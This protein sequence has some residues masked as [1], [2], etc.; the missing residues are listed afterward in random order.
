[1]SKFTTR[2]ILL[3]CHA[4]IHRAYHA[5]PDFSTRDGVPTGGLY[6]VCTMLIKAISD[7]RPDH[8]IA[9]YDLPKP[10]FRHIAYDDYKGGRAKTDEDLK[11][12]LQSSKEI[13]EA[14]GIPIYEQEGFE[15]DDLLGTIAEILKKDPSHEVI[16][17]SGDM[18][19]L[20]LV[21][22]DQ[23]KVFTLK[24]SINDTVLYNEDAVLERYGFGSDLI[25]DYK[26]L[27]GDPSDNIIGIKGIGAKTA[28]TLLTNFGTIEDIYTALEDTPERFSEL[29]ITPRIQGLL[30]DGET[31]ALFSKEL[32]TIKR[33]VPIEFAL[34]EIPF[35]KALDA[36]RIQTLFRKFEFRTMMD[37][38]SKILKLDL[39][40]AVSLFDSGSPTEAKHTPSGERATF[41]QSFEN[42]ETLSKALLAVYLLNPNQSDPTRS[43]V[44]QYGETLTSAYA[45]L[46]K[47]IGEQGLDF[48]W[49]E[50]EQPIVQILEQMNQIGFK[51]DRDRMK[52]LSAEFNGLLDTLEKEIHGYA[53]SEFNIRSTQ[54][55]GV[56]LFEDMGLPTKGIKKTSTGKYSTSESELEK[57][58]DTHPIVEKI[59]LHRTL[60]KLTGTYVD[61]LPPL[62]DPL[63][64]RLQST[65]VQTGTTTGRMASRDPN[66]QNIPTGS[67]AGDEHGQKIREMFIAREGCVLVACDYSQIEL[68]M[69]AELSGDE[70]FI[71][72]FSRG[73]DI[74]AA[75]A[76]ELF[77]SNEGDNRRKAKV[78]NFGILYGMGANA[79]RINLGT[80][81]HS[82]SD[83]R[84]YLDNYFSRFPT[85]S[86]YLEDSKQFAREHGYTKTLFGRRRYFPEIGSKIPFIRAAAERMAINAP[87]QGTATA[88][89]IKLAMRDV[90]GYIDS[91]KLGLEVIMISQIHDELLF[92]VSERGLDHM[93]AIRDLMEQVLERYGPKIGYAPR[94]PLVVGM[95]AGRTWADTK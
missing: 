37:R 67:K 22:G 73:D 78:I 33:D 25:P 87:I 57:I 18:D 72:V 64:G 28:T 68:R 92:E 40:P 14:F 77:G 71:E 82:Q 53:G 26:G 43:D 30:R 62:I 13:F 20:Q 47:E 51:I 54:Q 39:E 12:Q 76:T 56:T 6:G 95:H 11:K 58:R 80:D 35:E 90:A 55:L 93:E 44:L 85:L 45:Q 81:D 74:H 29:K 61:N 48:V 88:D 1:M 31:D 5:M 32:A 10:T 7:F 69:A 24:R 60:A 50:I 86:G 83:A 91:H 2:T 8:I 16:I 36:E 3:D 4:I 41:S 79:L 27:S 52:E 89:I 59:L 21:E 34:S 63:M 23:V 19:T 49:K 84:E 38:L 46:E 70:K 75:V 15:A 65:L 66:L 17:A 42:P 94:V 9:C